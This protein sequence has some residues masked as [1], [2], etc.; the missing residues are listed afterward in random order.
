[1][2]WSSK[3]AVKIQPTLLISKS[4]GDRFSYFSQH[5]IQFAHG[6]SALSYLGLSFNFF[7]DLSRGGSPN[8]L[9]QPPKLNIKQMDFIK[10][11]FLLMAKA[12]RRDPTQNLVG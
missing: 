4:E 12:N 3:V 6:P 11:S 10:A 2:P 8:S 1:M 7:F 9:C 5:F